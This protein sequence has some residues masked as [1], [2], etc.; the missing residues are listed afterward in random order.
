MRISF[1]KA[2]EVLLARNSCTASPEGSGRGAFF[3]TAAVLIHGPPERQC[4]LV[5]VMGPEQKDWE[6]RVKTDL[7]PYCEK[8][9][10]SGRR[11]TL[12]GILYTYTDP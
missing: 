1:S 10:Y 2:S 9:R 3:H 7:A 8:P 6:R 11:A 12:H 4:Q 5:K